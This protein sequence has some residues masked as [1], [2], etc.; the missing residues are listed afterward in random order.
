MP[1]TGIVSVFDGV[2]VY[3][4][5]LKLQNSVLQPAQDYV[6][7]GGLK[8]PGLAIVKNIVAP[9][10]WDKREGYGFSGASVVFHGAKLATFDVEFQLWLD[11]HWLAWKV[12]SQLLG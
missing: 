1:V 7:M 6:L 4:V 8:S 2:S 9:R 12:F 11:E 3:S 10:G 5:D